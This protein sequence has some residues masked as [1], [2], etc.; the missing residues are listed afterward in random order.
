M[1]IFQNAL[2]GNL[3]KKI[4]IIFTCFF[5]IQLLVGSFLIYQVTIQQTTDYLNQTTKRVREDILYRNGIWDTYR[6]NAD[7]NVPDT[8]PLYVLSADGFV[9][10]R[11]KPIHGFLDIS[12][13]KHLLSYQEPQTIITPTNQTWRI[14]SKPIV[15]NSETIGVITV[16]SFNPLSDTIPNIDEKLQNTISI[17]TSKLQFRNNNIDT[18]NLDPRDISFDVAF[19]VVDKYNRIVTKNNNTNSIDRIPNYIDTSYIGTV[20]NTPLVRQIRDSNSN[21]NFLIVTTPIVDQNNF[22]VGVI[23][24]GRTI[25]Y[26]DQ[27][28]QKFVIAEICLGFLSIIIFSLLSIKIIKSF[29]TKTKDIMLVKQKKLIDHISFDE[30]NSVLLFDHEEIAIPYATNQYYLCKTLFSNPKKRWEADELLKRFG[31]QDLTNWRKVYDAMLIL[32]KKVSQVINDKLII[33]RDKIYQIN[34]QLLSKIV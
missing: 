30:K 13:V 10:D 4:G 19:Q 33:A 12:D 28:L 24:I 7:P 5:L 22:I 3:A 27:I 29:I 23:V 32:N 15:H 17:I 2:Y 9:I 34:P 21:E 20:V 16:S 1:H 18:N 8:Y 31:D 11:W 25:S 14:L 6:Y 26:L